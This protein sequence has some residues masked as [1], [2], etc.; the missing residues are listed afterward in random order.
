[1]AP[2]ILRYDVRFAALWAVYAEQR[3]FIIASANDAG[4]PYEQIGMAVGLM[5]ARC[6]Q[7]ARKFRA[8]S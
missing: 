6:A 4:V 7:I 2:S 5:P 8:A 1:M 3:G